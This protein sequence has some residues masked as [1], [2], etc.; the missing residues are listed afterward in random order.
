MKITKCKAINYK[1]YF[2]AFNK[3]N[4]KNKESDR[5]GPTMIWTKMTWKYFTI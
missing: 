2:A 5:N 1:K 4:L 3:K